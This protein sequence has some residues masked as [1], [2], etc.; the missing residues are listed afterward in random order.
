M[1]NTI[2][3]DGCNTF[4]IKERIPYFYKKDNEKIQPRL[5]GVKNNIYYFE[6]KYRSPVKS[7]YNKNNTV[8]AQYIEP[9]NKKYAVVF[10]HGWSVSQGIKWLHFATL[11]AKSNIAVLFIELPYHIHRTPE[12]MR[13]GEL[14]IVADAV[15]TFNSFEQAV[16][17]V[18]KGI[19]FLNDRGFERIGIIGTSIGSMISVIVQAE[20]K[21]IDKSVLILSGGDIG[22]LKWKSFATKQLRRDHIKQGVTHNVCIER[23][24]AFKNFLEKVRRGKLPSEIEAPIACYYFDPLVFA[25]QIETDKVLMINGL[26]DVLIPRASTIKL[27]KELGKPKLIWYPL[28]HLTIYLAFPSIIKAISRFLL[29]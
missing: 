24:K 12:G 27:W 11:L 19:D 18:R 3:T 17:D 16:L 8:Y 1:K 26:F 10:L 9:K 7:I 6:L 15:K 13:S 22:L 21:M 14:F 2:S 20:D 25:P 28:S 23:R 29:N 4:D 5:T